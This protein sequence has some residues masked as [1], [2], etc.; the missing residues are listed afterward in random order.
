MLFW[1]DEVRC[2]IKL[3]L[4]DAVVWHTATRVG[5]VD[6]NHVWVVT[7]SED[8][9]CSLR[10]PSAYFHVTSYGNNT[11]SVPQRNRRLSKHYEKKR[12]QLLKLCKIFIHSFHHIFPSSSPSWTHH[13]Q[14]GTRT[15][16]DLNTVTLYG[17]NNT[18]QLSTGP[19]SCSQKEHWILKAL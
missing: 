18:Y 12:R 6:S 10:D 13:W 8:A 2:L 3:P 14:R 4:I 5:M 17:G 1:I 7:R 19:T 11:L 9:P 16:R 15:D